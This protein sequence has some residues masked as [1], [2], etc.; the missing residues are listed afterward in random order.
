[1]RIC[2][3]AGNNNGKLQLR[4]LK[5][6]SSAQ[7]IVRVIG[8]APG[9]STTRQITSAICGGL[10]GSVGWDLNEFKGFHKITQQSGSG[11]QIAI[12]A[13]N[14]NDG[15]CLEVELSNQTV[16]SHDLLKLETA[17]LNGYCKLGV[18]VVL[19]ARARFKISSHTISYLTFSKARHWLQIYSHLRVPILII[20]IE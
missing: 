2:R 4:N 5:Y 20:G 14:Q 9:S 7:D 10:R 19:T 3:I 13:R 6:S 12:D 17:F 15:I 16:F 11:R 1:M 18:V 8:A